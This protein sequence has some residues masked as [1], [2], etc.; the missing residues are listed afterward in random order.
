MADS[1]EDVA[2]SRQ[3]D[4]K[5]YSVKHE[6]PVVT[7]EFEGGYVATRPRN[8]RSP[9]RRIWT[10]GYTDIS[11]AD[12][13]LL[14]AFWNAQKGGSKIFIWLDFAAWDAAAWEAEQAGDD[15]PDKDPYRYNVRFSK[16]AQLTFEPKGYGRNLRYDVPALTIEES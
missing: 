9:L 8:G 10:F 2:L 5:Y 3:P 1:F 12:R 7:T 15:E 11:T 13:A 6:N 16:D 14:E 4:R